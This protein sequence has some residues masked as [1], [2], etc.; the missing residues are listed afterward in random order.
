MENTQNEGTKPGDTPEEK[1]DYT[2]WIIGGV[3]VLVV[4]YVAQMFL[5]P[6]RMMERHIERAIEREGGGNVDIDF[7]RGGRR[8]EETNITFSGENG[9]TYTINT[10]GDVELPENW[11]QSVPLPSNAK[12]MYAGSMGMGQSDGGMTVSYM[13]SDSVKE[14]NEYYS[15]ELKTNGWTIGATS[16][17][18]EGGM[19]SAMR[20]EGEALIVYIGASPDGTSVSLTVQERN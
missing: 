4:L 12:V 19:I 6:G 13:I 5:T 9:E 10:G 1:K 2:K 11:P 20:N 17:T 18:P 8:G 15:R 7:D 3:V 14:M 16:A